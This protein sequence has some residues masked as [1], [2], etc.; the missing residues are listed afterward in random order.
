MSLLDLELVEPDVFLAPTPAEGPPRLFGGQVASQALRASTLTVDSD[1]RVHS[2]HSYFIRPGRPNVPLRLEVERTRDGKSFTTRRVTA[3]QDKESIFV[4]ESSFH[5]EEE[6]YDWQADP[7]PLSP[8]PDEIAA[9]DGPMGMRLP[10]GANRPPWARRSAEAENGADAAADNA[11][12][13][14]SAAGSSTPRPPRGNP[15]RGMVEIK[16]LQLDEEW[17][18]HPAWVRVVQPLGDDP[19]IHACALTYISD[20]AVVSAARAPGSPIRSW[21]GASLDHTVW[22][23][24]PFRVDEWLLFSAEP[25]TNYGARGLARGSFHTR[26]GVLVASFVQECL[27]RSTGTPP[28]P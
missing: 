28:P 6:G 21:G 24:R 9:G 18:P 5:V 23:H 2:L 19:S 16:P 1:R 13:N 14:E 17:R 20:M 3:R 27:L 25:L 15:F 8:G 4:L 10:T 12:D 26:D 7:P 11:G 22:F